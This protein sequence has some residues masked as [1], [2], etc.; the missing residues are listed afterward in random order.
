MSRDHGA[1]G[2][3]PESVYVI[4]AR[5]GENGHGGNVADRMLFEA[6]RGRTRESRR[7]IAPIDRKS[8][9]YEVGNYCDSIHRQ[10]QSLT[11]LVDEVKCPRP[12]LPGRTAKH[13]ELRG[14]TPGVHNVRE[15]SVCAYCA[16]PSLAGGVVVI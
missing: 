16:L 12:S 13:D 5:F 2:E 14:P 7:K 15:V 4:D 3:L 6:T 1:S 10:V 9:Q 8:F 11:R